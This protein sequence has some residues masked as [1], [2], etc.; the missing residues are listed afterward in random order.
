MTLTI[1][2]IEFDSVRYDREA[3]V[4]Y[5]PAGFPPTELPAAW[6]LG[7]GL[8]NMFPSTPGCPSYL[9]ESRAPLPHLRLAPTGGVSADNAA[10][11]I[12]A[13]AYALGVGSAL[14]DRSLVARGDWPALADRA[15]R[16]VDAVASAR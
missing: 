2:N 11:F 10:A 6:G 8:V 7:T 4:L 9:K 16:L 5:M 3:D 14:V 12:T 1:A 13:G 15:R